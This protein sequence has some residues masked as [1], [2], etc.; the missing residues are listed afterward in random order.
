MWRWSVPM[1]YWTGFSSGCFHSRRSATSSFPVGPA[2]ENQFAFIPGKSAQL[3]PP[4][5]AGE[6]RIILKD[7][8]RPFIGQFGCF[9][10]NRFDAFDTD[11]YFNISR[12]AS[13]P[14]EHLNYPYEDQT[15]DN[16]ATFALI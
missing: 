11:L 4:V 7:F 8:N 5:F 10:K 2:I 9:G 6:E 1:M 16:D 3:Q 13:L 12:H 15:T 14:D